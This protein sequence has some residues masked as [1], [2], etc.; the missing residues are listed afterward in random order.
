MA[1]PEETIIRGGDNGVWQILQWNE[2]RPPEIEW[3]FHPDPDKVKCRTI[4]LIQIA[5]VHAVKPQ[6]GAEVEL[7]APCDD[8]WRDPP[9]Y[10]YTKPDRVKDSAGHEVFVDHKACEGDPFLNGDDV[11]KDGGRPGDPK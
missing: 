4:Y 3:K 7:G 10:G 5:H 6:G 2:K 11:G 8:W 9:P 1:E